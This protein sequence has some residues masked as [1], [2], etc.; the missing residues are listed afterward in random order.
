MV[1]GVVQGLH[2]KGGGPRLH[3]RGCGPRLHGRGANHFLH[4]C[5]MEKSYLHN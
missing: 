1:G 5:S 2:G 4:V 3:G